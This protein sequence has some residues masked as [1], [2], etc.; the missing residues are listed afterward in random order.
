MR[1]TGQRTGPCRETN[2]HQHA[3]ITFRWWK[4]VNVIEVLGVRM[5]CELSPNQ[6]VPLACTAK[7]GLSCTQL[8]QADSHCLYISLCPAPKG[9]RFRVCYMLRGCG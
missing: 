7:A 5:T 9:I 2:T 8:A 4:V 1:A 6:T 3:C